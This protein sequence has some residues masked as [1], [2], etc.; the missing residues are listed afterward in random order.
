MIVIENTMS[1][2]IELV[3]NIDLDVEGCRLA[4]PPPPPETLA[5]GETVCMM[6]YEPGISYTIRPVK[7]PERPRSHTIP[8][9]K[10]N[11]HG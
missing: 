6:G 1:E 9:G 8:P 2:D 10:D 7:D 3:T 4:L 11:D 5:P